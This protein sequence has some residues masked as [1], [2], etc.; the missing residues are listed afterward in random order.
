MPDEHRHHLE[1]DEMEG[2]PW[3][4][5][6]AAQEQAEE[7]RDTMQ[8]ELVFYMSNKDIL[9]DRYCTANNGPCG[10]RPVVRAFK[11]GSTWE[12]LF[13]GCERYRHRETGHIFIPLRNHDPKAVL[14][15]WG[16]TRSWVPED[17][18]ADLDFDWDEENDGTISIFFPS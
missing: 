10:G 14:K 9:C 18:L 12:R 7:S 11:S 6:L 16:K 13:I 3:A 4:R 15:I 1:V 8:T 17:I 5:L 2:H